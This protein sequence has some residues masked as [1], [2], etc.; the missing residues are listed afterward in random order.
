MQNKFR[1]VGRQTKLMKEAIYSKNTGRLNRD[2]NVFEQA[3]TRRKSGRRRG[4]RIRLISED[5]K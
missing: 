2:E 5:N 4:D 1:E 3:K